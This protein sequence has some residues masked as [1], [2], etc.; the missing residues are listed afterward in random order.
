MI[1]AIVFDLDHTLF[2]RHA[3]LRAIA[4]HLRERFAVNPAL[5]DDELAALW[6]YADDR[7]VYDGW[8]YV[9]AY[10]VEKGMFITPPPYEDYRSFI[11]EFFE[12]IA[13]RFDFALPLL[14]DLKNRGYKVGLIT[15]GQHALQYKK[16]ELTGMRYVFDEII[17]SGDVGVEKPDREIFFI[18]CEKLGVSPAEMLYVGDNPVND[19]DGAA[20]A[21]CR[22]VWVRSTRVSCC[23]KYQPDEV[24]NDVSELPDVLTHL[25]GRTQRTVQPG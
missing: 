19:V 17:V 8:R 23:G 12:K 25:Q 21:G 16:L 22:T 7:F 10:L 6:I 3:T 1:K 4:P 13:V 20:G 11:F 9:F 15:N 18:M 2:D 24:V 5:S 14:E